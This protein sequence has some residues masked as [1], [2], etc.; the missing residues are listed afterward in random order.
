MKVDLSFFFPCMAAERYGQQ[1]Q[2]RV[3][4]EDS[5]SVTASQCCDRVVFGPGDE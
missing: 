1:S 2:C 4:G 3:R 5:I